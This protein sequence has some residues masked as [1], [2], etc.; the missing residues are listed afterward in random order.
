MCSSIFTPIC[1]K[2]SLNASPL[3]SVQ[4][5]SFLLVRIFPQSD[6]IRRFNSSLLLRKSP[7]SV[8]MREDTNQKKVRIWTL[9]SGEAAKNGL[10]LIYIYYI[11]FYQIYCRLNLLQRVGRC[12]KFSIKTKVWLIPY[13][14][15]LVSYYLH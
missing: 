13:S 8:R 9:F 2:C 11:A 7:Y 3:K 14:N 15:E 12:R 1:F 10:N 4:I 6:R 5:R